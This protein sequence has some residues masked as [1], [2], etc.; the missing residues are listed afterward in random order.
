[1]SKKDIARDEREWMRAFALRKDLAQYVTTGF[2]SRAAL[3]DFCKEHSCS[4]SSAYRWL[5]RAQKDDRAAALLRIRPGPKLMS[6]R[7]SDAHEAIIT[8]FIRHEFLTRNRIKL[9]RVL[10]LT[11]S[12]L[13][14]Q[15][16]HTISMSALKCRIVTLPDRLVTQKREGSK[17]ARQ[18]F[19]IVKGRYEVKDPLSVVQVDHTKLDVMVV[20]LET[21]EC[22]GRPYLTTLIDLATRM[23]TGIFLSM[24][25][26]SAVNLMMAFHRSVFPKTDYLAVLGIPHEWPAHGIPQTI[27]SDNGADLKS[28]AFNRGL[29]QYGI[30]HIFRPIAQPHLGGHV[31]RFIGTIQT[32]VQTLPGTTFSNVGAKGTYQPEKQARLTLLDVER[33]ILNYMLG[34]YVGDKKRRLLTTPLNMW[35]VSWQESGALPRLP[36]DPHR[37]RLDFL[38][39]E[40]RKIQREGLEIFGMFYR[41][42]ALQKMKNCG[43]QNVTVKY[44]PT[45]IRII[46]ISADDETYFDARSEKYPH[47]PLSL[48]D[49][50]RI[51][52]DRDERLNRN[53]SAPDPALAHDFQKQILHEAK[54]RYRNINGKFGSR[55]PSGQDIRNLGDYETPQGWRDQS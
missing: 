52:R 51:N 20:D 24:D 36:Q 31:E 29:D 54:Q 12:E 49:W 50:N 14:G 5:A 27:S 35:N 55:L 45:D 23:P 47:Y 34:E 16:L 6:T 39:F 41:C 4:R 21:G 9:S 44:D 2:Q 22:I 38:P 18:D 33:L 46:H 42:D 3:M 32:F 11:N 10:K 26:P 37:F 53:L 17:A 43:V 7:L 48:D 25:A 13:A 15:G 1:M 28:K 30:E 40:Q 8:R 19:Q